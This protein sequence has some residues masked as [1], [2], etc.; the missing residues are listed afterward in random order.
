MGS[1]QGKR[2]V[3]VSLL[4][5]AGH[6][7][8]LLLILK[9]LETEGAY[10]HAVVPD[11][12]EAQVRSFG[13]S[14]DLVGPVVPEDGRRF[15]RTLSRSGRWKHVFFTHLESQKRYFLPL[16]YQ[17][18]QRRPVIANK[19]RHLQCDALLCD[20]H[21]FLDEY[22]SM[23]AELGVPLLVHEATGTLYRLQEWRDPL[24]KG[25]P[26]SGLV[27][28]LALQH[29]PAWH[30]RFNKLFRRRQ[31]KAWREM[32]R[33]VNEQ[34]AGYLTPTPDMVH[35]ITTGTANIENKHLFGGTQASDDFIRIG[36][37]DPQSDWGAG[38]EVMDWLAGCDDNSVVYLSFGTQASPPDRLVHRIISHSRSLGKKV[39]VGSGTL[40]E[41][42]LCKYGES[43]RWVGWAPQASVLA[44]PK[45]CA[46]VSHMGANSYREALWF[47]KPVLAVPLLWDQ[48]YCAWAAQTLGV[49]RVIRDFRIGERDLH[50]MVSD[51]VF[52]KKY[53][54]NARCLSSE[55]KAENGDEQVVRFVRNLLATNDDVS[56]VTWMSPVG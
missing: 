20:S 52:N 35:R 18:V 15:L 44:S 54:A 2:I 26:F 43:V 24:G 5:D 19:L 53:E 36:S 10:V 7:K 1:L 32:N 23:S 40:P 56:G 31:F 17:G 16:T 42:A 47:G 12:A 9:N 51:V 3:M 25:S 41:S 14:C 21:I 34:R 11:E 4:P 49:G 30:Y 39:L 28:R 29:M 33:L 8:S 46:F 55:L 37:L 38:Q 48:Y 45:V 13:F 50:D 27:E 22:G 6:L